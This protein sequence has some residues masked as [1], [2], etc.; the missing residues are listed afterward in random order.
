MAVTFNEIVNEVRSTLRGYGLV[1]EQVTFLNGSIN[2][3][4]LAATVDDG[5]LLQ[6]GVIEIDSE[7]LWVQSI[8]TNALTISPDGRGWD[9]TTAASH[10]DNARVILDPAWPKWRIERAVNDTIVGAAPDIYGVGTTSF[11]YNPSVQT[12]SVPADAEGVLKVTADTIGPSLNQD[13]IYE[14]KFN[15]SAP[16]GEFATGNCVTLLRA[17][18]P[19]RT[20]TVAYR[21]NPSAL[22]SGDDL[23]DAGLNDSARALIVYGAVGRL[24]SLVDVSRVHTGTAVSAEFADVNR[25]GTATQL[26]AQVSARY[27]MELSQERRRLDMTYPPRVTWRGR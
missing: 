7:C 13:E 9:G 2:S 10:A 6:P 20:V 25:V 22:A 19:G 5:S 1:R 3:S 4:V 24:L 11:T 8:A 15:S 14:Y 18:F 27:Q 21:K 16:T 17:P 12:Y 26:A 23:S